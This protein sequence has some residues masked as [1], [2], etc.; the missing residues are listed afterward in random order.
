M[1]LLMAWGETYDFLTNTMS[2]I[3]IRINAN[4]FLQAMSET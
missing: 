3:Q 4:M 2:Q 1:S